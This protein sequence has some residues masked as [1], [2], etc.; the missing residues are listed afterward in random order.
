MNP[1]LLFALVG[2]LAL[3]VTAACDSEG[4]SPTVTTGPASPT[5]SASPAEAVTE[6]PTPASAPGFIEGSLGYPASA[7]PPE[8][9]VCAENATTG[10]RT[11]TEEHIKDS[12]FTYFEGYELA[13][14]PGPYRVFASLPH[15]DFRGYYSEAV[16]CALGPECQSYDPLVVQVE[17]GRR[18][19]EI[20]PIDFYGPA[21]AVATPTPIAAVSTGDTC[22]IS[23]ESLHRGARTP[24]CRAR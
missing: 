24:G 19:T 5:I 16:V 18:V 15:T 23:G 21:T 12:R 4:T 20:D 2:P 9:M 7:I 10:E 1:R 14:A 13:L 8:L 6:S 22:P 3:L 17:A 11:C